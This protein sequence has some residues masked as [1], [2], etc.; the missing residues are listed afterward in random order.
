MY[1]K[2][3]GILGFIKTEGLKAFNK[4]H[5]KK[6]EMYYNEIQFFIHYSF[7]H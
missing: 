5:P 2:F 3:L 6:L 1:H 7:I 4:N